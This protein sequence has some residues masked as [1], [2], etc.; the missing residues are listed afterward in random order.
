METKP[1]TQM[2]SS[3]GFTY[4]VKLY[5]NQTVSTKNDEI[6]DRPLN[7]ALRIKSQQVYTNKP[8]PPHH[9]G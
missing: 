8:N 5:G 9:P 1:I 6:W 3:F 7:T 2:K 4:M